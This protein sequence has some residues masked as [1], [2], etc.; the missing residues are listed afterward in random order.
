MVQAVEVVRK[1]SFLYLG[2]A[3]YLFMTIEIKKV[4]GFQSFRIRMFGL[5]FNTL[6]YVS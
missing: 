6:G 3:Y 4:L 5:W 2:D 1:M